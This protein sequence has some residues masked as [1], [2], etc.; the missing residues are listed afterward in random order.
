MLIS[1]HQPEVPVAY[2]Y[3]NLT[4]MNLNE[5]LYTLYKPEAPHTSR[6]PSLSSY[7]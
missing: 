5:L 7:R 4:G 2:C 6:V 1:A 3:V